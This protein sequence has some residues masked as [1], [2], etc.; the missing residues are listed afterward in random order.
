M[1]LYEGLSAISQNRFPC[2][3]FDIGGINDRFAALLPAGFYYKTFMWPRSFWDRVYEPLI[4]AAAGL[5]RVPTAPDPDR[6]LQRH[7]HC[8]VLVIGAG[9]AGLAAAL[10]AADAGAR[11]ILCD[12]Q[13][14]MGG[15]LLADTH[16]H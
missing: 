3:H 16:V 15:S 7:A 8:E 10:A 5:G 4:R 6:Y 14:E 13:A 9:P 12:E 11:V 1:E 2:L